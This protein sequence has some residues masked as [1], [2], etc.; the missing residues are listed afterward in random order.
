MSRLRYLAY[1][2]NLLPQR[3]QRRVPSAR[4]LTAVRLPG[5]SLRFHKRGQDGSAKC[6]LLESRRE[7]DCAYGAIYD[8]AAQERGKLDRAEGLGK[9]Y[10]LTWLDL[11][12]IGRVFLYAAAQTHIDDHLRP[13]RWYRAFVEAG[14]AYHG[15]PEEYVTGIRAVEAVDDPLPERHRQ[16]L[17]L[18]G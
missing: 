5:V 15:F 3:L 11:E 9:G 13:F 1:G 18:L 7:T 8:I 2:S 12:A 17:A 6:N 4:T 16:N 10:E 14:A